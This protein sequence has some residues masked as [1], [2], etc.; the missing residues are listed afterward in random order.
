MGQGTFRNALCYRLNITKVHLPPL[1]ERKDDIPGL[2]T[3]FL[4]MLN[5]QMGRQVVSLEPEVHDCLMEHAWPSNVREFKNLLESTL[6]TIRSSMIQFKDLPGQY[7]TTFSQ[8]QSKPFLERERLVLALAATHWN[9]SKTAKQRG[10]GRMMVY[11]KIAHYGIERSCAGMMSQTS[12]L[13]V[14]T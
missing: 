3:Y 11:R 9:I 4:G 5:A 12:N 1:R 14:G 7:Q 2:I 13:F 10:W 8:V 6:L